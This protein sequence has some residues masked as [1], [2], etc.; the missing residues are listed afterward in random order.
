[1]NFGQE[2]RAKCKKCGK[3]APA[4]EFKMHY[5]YRM[6]VC[7]T[8]FKGQP[9]PVVP[10]APKEEPVA[11]KA[12]GWDKEDEYLEKVTKKKQE[13]QTSTFQSI[14][15]SPYVQCKCIHCKYT[16]KYDGIRKTP[17]SCPYCNNPVPKYTSK[18]F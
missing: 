17:S 5:E 14:P 15:G 1:M 12:P 13:Q 16:F 11:P 3:D 2:V 6:M 10:N 9:K 8:C 7:P 4:S 18:Q